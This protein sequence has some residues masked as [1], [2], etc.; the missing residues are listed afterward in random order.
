MRENYTPSEQYTKKKIFV[1]TENC[2]QTQGFVSFSL[3]GKKTNSFHQL[4]VEFSSHPTNAT[5]FGLR[6]H[7]PLPLGRETSFSASA[8][9]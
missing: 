7:S 3:L 1:H 5:R 8:W 6:S 2:Q 9:G 4:Q